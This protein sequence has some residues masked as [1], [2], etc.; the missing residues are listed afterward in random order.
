[1]P[2]ERRGAAA[3]AR[4]LRDF[5]LDSVERGRRAGPSQYLQVRYED[6]ARDPAAVLRLI[7]AFIGEDY[8]P[9]MLDPS[10]RGQAL[11]PSASWQARAAQ[12]IAPLANKWRAKLTPADRVR[13]QAIVR[14][15]LAP[16]GYSDPTKLVRTLTPLARV[17]VRVR[18]LVPSTVVRLRRPKTPE[19]RYRA[20]RALMQSAADRVGA[21]PT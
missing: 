13:V 3:V 5:T 14:D 2:W 9:G 7:C 17:E 6:L 1:M 10:R 12:P 16:Y 15:L 20:V 18:S 11:M 8:D 21:A 4:D 19:A